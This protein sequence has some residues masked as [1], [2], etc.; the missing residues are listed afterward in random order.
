VFLQEVEAEYDDLI[1]YMEVHWLSWGTVLQHFV[2]IC[3]EV[4]YFL[5]GDKKLGIKTYFSCV[6]LPAMSA[7][8]MNNFRACLNLP[9]I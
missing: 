2:N 7:T 1:Y 9:L 3:S 6:S 4:V 5:E 8:S